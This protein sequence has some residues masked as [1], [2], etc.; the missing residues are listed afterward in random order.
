MSQLID[1]RLNGKHKNAVNRQ[2]FLRRYRSQIKRAVSD[3]VAGRNITDM[4]KGEE[5]SIPA[6]DISEPVFGHGTG[7]RRER[8]Y[9]GNR[10][11]T[12]G[13]RIDRPPSGDGKGSGASRNEGGQDDFTFSISQ[14]EF[15]DFFFEDLALPDLV[16]TQLARI[17]EH[18][19]V[20]AGH[21][22]SGVPTN[23]DVIRS[24]RGA[25]ARRT[26]IGGPLRRRLRQLEAELAELSGTDDDVP[27]RR[28][29][30]EAEVADLERRLARIPF[31][32]TF[33]LRY[34]NHVPQPKPATQ[35]VMFCLMDVSGSMDAARKDIAKRFF[36]L[37][38][39][40]LSRNYER[41]EV[42]FIRHHTTAMEVDEHDFFYARETGGTVVSSALELTH[43]IIRRRYPTADWNIYVAQASDG[44]NWDDDSPLCR[45]LLTD[46]LMPCVQYYA[47]VE[48]G[49]D[50]PQN[51][52]REYARVQAAHSHFAMQRIKTA[53]DIYGV[54]REL[55][56]RKQAA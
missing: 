37:L 40:F 10:D 46:K 8:V 45:K 44:D 1:R 39:L 27:Q 28:T 34:R 3:A 9:P 14:A 43:D 6:R 29:A 25:Q 31:I 17:T 32:D 24:L 33:D 30:L 13:D 52:W 36:I 15:L 41:I 49:A 50:T 18:K 51:L 47:Y 21:T 35:A 4:D 38:Y 12:A 42:V 16:K 11:Y 2:R 55:F 48:I 20:R 56:S 7:G 23:I 5:V 26:A 54:F 19:P 22:P 53:Q